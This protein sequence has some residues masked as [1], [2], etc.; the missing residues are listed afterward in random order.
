MKVLLATDGSPSSEAAIREVALR[1]WPDEEVEVLTVV[2]TRLPLV[3]DPVLV[4]AASY[5]ELL[6]EARQKAPEIVEK[7]AKQIR[8]Q[9]PHL[10]VVTKVLEGAPKE[11]IVEEAEKWGADLIVLGSHGYG[12]VSRFLLGSVAHA[13]ALH[14][15]CS[16][17]I[18]RSRQGAPR[19]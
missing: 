14:A 12:P 16:V 6:R 11:L 9:A 1:H 13:V 10:R 15:P 4:L 3:S 17:Q 18:V 8:T 2:H 5:Q 7:A 19:A